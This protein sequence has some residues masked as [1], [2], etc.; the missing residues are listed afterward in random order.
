MLTIIVS[1]VLV[2]HVLGIPCALEGRLAT[3]SEIPLRGGNNDGKAK[4]DECHDLF[5][6]D[7]ELTFLPASPA[8]L[9][10]AELL[11]TLARCF[12]LLPEQVGS[13]EA[14]VGAVAIEWEAVVGV[15]R[16][17][18]GVVHLHHHG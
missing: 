11:W 16:L 14:E 10:H 6:D 7:D 8:I 3:R 13:W 12:P 17:A 15:V 1:T 4:T 2:L 5:G 18:V 9:I